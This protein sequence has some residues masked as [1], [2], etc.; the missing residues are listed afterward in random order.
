MN[1]EVEYSKKSFVSLTRKTIYLSLLTCLLVPVLVIASFGAMMGARGIFVIGFLAAGL[2]GCGGWFLLQLWERKMQRS[3]SQLVQAR[4]ERLHDFPADLPLSQ[5]QRYEIEIQRLSDE[6]EK[7]RIGYEHQISLMQSSVAK[8]KEEV[9]QLHFDMDKKLEEMRLA[10][11]EF[12]DLR[13]EYR[14]LDEE[15]KHRIA[16]RQQSLENRETLINEYQR[17]VAEQRMIIEKKQ[18]YIANLET[19]VRDQMYEIRSLLQLEAPIKPGPIEERVDVPEHE[20]YS[21]T[22]HAPQTPY[23]FSIQLHRYI[24]KAEHLTGVDHLGYL[25]GKSPRFLDFSLDGY[26]VDK[27]RLF[28]SFK[29]ETGGTVFIYSLAEKKFLFVNPAVKGLTGWSQEKFM[30]EFPRL[31]ARGYPEWEEAMGKIKVVKE[32]ALRLSILNR[33]NQPRPVDCYMGL[34]GKGPFGQHVIGILVAQ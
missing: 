12:E 6:L 7:T 22:A 33:S 32:Y 17:T 3:V 5:V 8:S 9:Q 20:S 27:R 14:R 34:I 26:A 29:D 1:T 16:E 25:G 28:D 10:Y 24:E 23:D 31:V 2:G 15:S 30:K 13:Q 18:R 11:L 19:K 4:M 21:P